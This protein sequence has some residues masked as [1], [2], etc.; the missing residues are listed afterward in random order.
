[1]GEL[2]THE[3]AWQRISKL[4]KRR[5]SRCQVAVAYFN[6][7]A[8]DLLPLKRGSTLVVDLSERA[9]GSGQ[10]KPTEVGKL[11]KKGVD[12][13]SVENLH[14]KVFVIGNRALV[15][16]SNAS[17]NS[18]HRLIE[19]LIDTSET[20]I[21]S[22]CRKFVFGLRGEPVT[23]GQIKRLAK[24][25]HPPKF[26][27]ASGKKRKRHRTVPSH[28]ALWAVALELDD[29]DKADREAEKRSEDRAKPRLSSSRRF[30]IDGF[31]LY[32]SWTNRIRPNNMVIQVVSENAAA[33]MVSPPSRVLDITSYR[34]GN[35][36]FEM[37]SVEA[38]LKQRRKALPR[39]IAA[40]PPSGSVLKSNRLTK[41][42]D[43]LLAH[44]IM[45]LW[46]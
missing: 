45:S 28:A 12:V 7:G 30:F 10:T 24:H 35:R 37:L 8:S 9:V 34:K 14:A 19:A 27:F 17:S 29:F 22:A 16:S 20:S 21:V 25:W 41:I 32:G 31:K 2:L 42:S 6:A 13:Y 4:A 46:P 15:G 23:P 5:P 1:M 43:P 36:R 38:S 3:K 26:G 11:L 44:A 39:V 40:L 33:P 18:A